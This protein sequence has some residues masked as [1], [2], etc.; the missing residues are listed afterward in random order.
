MERGSGR[1]KRELAK[2]TTESLEKT[3]G[4]RRK[5]NAWSLGQKNNR[6]CGREQPSVNGSDEMR[7][8]GLGKGER[9]GQY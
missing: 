5:K 9:D 6:Y 3:G 1:K 4:E 2:K 7:E 8:E